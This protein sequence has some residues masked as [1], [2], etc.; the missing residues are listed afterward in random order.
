[1]PCQ[2]RCWR[3]GVSPAERNGTPQ[4][5]YEINMKLASRVSV[6]WPIG[7]MMAAVFSCT[8]MENPNE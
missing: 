5:T 4:N 1:M 6:N 7:A 8:R 3:V 2:R